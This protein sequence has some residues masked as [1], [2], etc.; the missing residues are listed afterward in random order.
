MPNNQIDAFIKIYAKENG[1]DLIV[2]T[3][4]SGNVLYGAD[5]IDVT[6]ELLKALNEQYK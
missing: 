1:F 4:S 2:G 6:E 3:T 5:G